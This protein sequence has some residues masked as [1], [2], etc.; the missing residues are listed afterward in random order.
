MG[1]VWLR[2]VPSCHR[3]VFSP[4]SETWGAHVARGDE[5]VRRK[6]CAGGSAMVI[7]IG[8]RFLSLR[9]TMYLRCNHV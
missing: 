1:Y 2:R 9:L 3:S 5:Y 8:L 7:T 4:G 6:E